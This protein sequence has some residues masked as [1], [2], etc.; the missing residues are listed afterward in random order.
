MTMAVQRESSELVF[1]LCM[2]LEA[3]IPVHQMPTR[4]PWLVFFFLQL[5]GQLVKRVGDRCEL[6]VGRMGEFFS[7]KRGGQG[8]VKGGK[9]MRTCMSKP[10]MTGHW[11][12]R[13]YSRVCK[14]GEG[15]E[16]REESKRT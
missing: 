7:V 4:F 13:G 6:L 14:A 12:G 3:I 11:S 9:W 15:R 16:M 10:T 5:W 8:W 2:R 1:C